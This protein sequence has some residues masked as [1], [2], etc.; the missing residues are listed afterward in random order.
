[1]R[2][3]KTMKIVPEPEELNKA[4]RAPN[5]VNGC[6]ARLIHVVEN[7]PSTE[8]PGVRSAVE[9]EPGLQQ[10]LENGMTRHPNNH[11][12]SA[13]WIKSNDR[14]SHQLYKERHVD[15]T[16]KAL[17]SSLLSGVDQGKD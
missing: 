15:G 8:Y 13:T 2:S 1:M 14:R 16:G 12:S 11:T 3:E 5:D 7:V 17:G 9:S 6:T 10:E 4:V